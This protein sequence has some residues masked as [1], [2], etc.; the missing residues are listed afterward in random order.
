MTPICRTDLPLLKN[1]TT[2][3]RNFKPSSAA[4]KWILFN[5]DKRVLSVQ[6][7]GNVDT[8][9]EGTDGLFEQFDLIGDKFICAYEA[10]A[11]PA[12]Y[13]VVVVP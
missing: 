5:D 1:P 8:R 12:I 4:G 9:N 13:G 7:N 3:T 11:L 2:W 10:C 6:P